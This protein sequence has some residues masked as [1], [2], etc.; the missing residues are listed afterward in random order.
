MA[1]IDAM[2]QKV[3]EMG[4]SDLHLVS[5]SVPYIRVYGDLKPVNMPQPMSHE[6]VKSVI[7]EILTE[8][9]RK[10]IEA[11]K[12][13]DLSYEVPGLGRFRGNILYQRKGM[14]AVFRCIPSEVSTLESLGFPP[15]VEKLTEHHQGLILVTGSTRS[16][17]STTLN[18]LI[19]TINEREHAHILTIEDP[20]EYVHTNKKSVINQREV[21]KHT[22]SFARALKAALREDPDVIM[23]GELRDT[24]TMSMAITAAETGHLVLAT[25]QTASAHKT[26]D[27]I[28]DSFPPKQQSQIR[29]MVSESIKGVVAQQLLKRTDGKGL[30]AAYEILIGTLPLANLI[31]EGKTFQIPSVMQTGAALGMVRMDDCIRDLLNKKI[32]A[33]EEA[34]RCANDKAAFAQFLPK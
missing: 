27:R 11:E 25:L 13:L 21:G 18:S 14:D 9:Q 17:K 15:V 3:K 2:F 7:F 33:P 4:A 10:K 22:N 26:I 31:R 23:V 5:G 28:L 6:V 29:T 20:I 34:Y 1:K 12:D 19:D 8:E 30:V 16:G 32:I 24:E